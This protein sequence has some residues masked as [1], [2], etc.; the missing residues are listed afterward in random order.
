MYTP[1]PSGA[2]Q[3]I[4]TQQGINVLTI[5]EQVSMSTIHTPRN[6]MKDSATPLPI[7]FEHLASPMVHPIT[8][9]MISSYKK[10]MHDPAMADVWQT[11]F[12]K[13]FGK[14]THGCNKTGQKGTKAMFV[15][16]HDK[17]HHALAA[18]FFLL[19]Q[20]LLSIIVHKRT[21]HI[22]STSWP[23]AT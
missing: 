22:A 8:G 18:I 3:R 4:M 2:R 16:T 14:M 17:I 9:K 10:L 23:G 20:I 21:I 11:A 12:G 6:L 19:T 15:M 13:D 1:I 7:K 5:Q